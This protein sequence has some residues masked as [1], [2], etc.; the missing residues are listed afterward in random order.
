MEFENKNFGIC[1]LLQCN[2]EK[3]VCLVEI[4][5]KNRAMPFVITSVIM[6]DG[7]WI[8]GEYYSTL[9]EAEGVYATKIIEKVLGAKNDSKISK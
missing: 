1:R 9:K 7:N 5:D 8:K 6:Q 4:K 2:Y 3:G